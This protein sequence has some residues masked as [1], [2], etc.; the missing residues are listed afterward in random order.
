[1]RRIGKIVCIFLIVIYSLS[2]TIYGKI[3]KEAQGN[4]LVIRVTDLKSLEE[5]TNSLKEVLGEYG[6]QGPTGSD[7]RT[8]DMETTVKIAGTKYTN[9]AGYTGV[10]NEPRIQYSIYIDG[11]YKRGGGN[12]QENAK[13]VAKEVLLENTGYSYPGELVIGENKL[14]WKANA[15]VKYEGK[16]HPFLGYYEY[17]Y[18]VTI[19]GTAISEEKNDESDKLNDWDHGQPNAPGYDEANPNGGGQSVAQQQNGGSSGSSSSSTSGSSAAANAFGS[20]GVKMVDGVTTAMVD[21]SESDANAEQYKP[22]DITD[23]GSLISK[24][25]VIV[26]IIRNIGIVVGVIGLTAIGV[27][28]M[29]ASITEKAEYKETMMPY[30]LG[31]VLLMAGT[32]VIDLIYQVAI[33]LG[34]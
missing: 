16:N 12:S 17:I 22:T 10:S 21:P 18:T 32:I 6:Y 11:E 13:K 19:T 33:T 31:C 25:G 5:Q 30:L 28:Y 2:T 29:F 26:G 3:K 23:A 7:E 14:K 15:T 9:S 24:A 34:K 27:R 20:S 4:S 1:M 8:W